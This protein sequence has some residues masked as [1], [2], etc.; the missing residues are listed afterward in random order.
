M[1]TF[2]GFHPVVIFVTLVSVSVGFGGLRLFC[3]APGL[4]QE[5]TGPLSGGHCPPSPA[6]RSAPIR[7]CLALADHP[8]CPA[9][10]TQLLHCCEPHALAIE[11]RMAARQSVL[12]P[13]LRLLLSSHGP[14]SCAT[15]HKSGRACWKPR[16]KLNPFFPKKIS[17]N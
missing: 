3:Q 11:T 10:C 17:I 16:K 15:A 9:L 2:L 6:S 12:P 8:Q 14:S 5:A 7:T 4:P 13:N 1:L